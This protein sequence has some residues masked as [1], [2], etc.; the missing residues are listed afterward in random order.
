MVDDVKL[1]LDDKE[2]GEDDDA[3]LFFQHS[4]RHHS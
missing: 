2:L 1:Y 4:M 3:I